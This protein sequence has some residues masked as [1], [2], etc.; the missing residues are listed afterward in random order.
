MFGIRFLRW[1]TFRDGRR[2]AR[3]VRKTWSDHVSRPPRLHIQR[4][5]DGFGAHLISGWSGKS[6]INRPAICSG[7]YF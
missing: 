5:V 2:T 1:P 4:L 3:P 6:T 7:E